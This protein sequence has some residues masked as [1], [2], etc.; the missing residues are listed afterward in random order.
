MMCHGVVFSQTE[1]SN[2]SYNHIVPEKTTNQIQT[3]VYNESLISDIEQR[4]PLN[5]IDFTI[6]V[7]LEEKDFIEQVE[8]LKSSKRKDKQ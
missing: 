3:S 1:A 7:Y 8:R 5:E 4:V 6:V 2:A